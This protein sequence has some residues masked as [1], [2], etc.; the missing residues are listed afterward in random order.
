MV[1]MANTHNTAP[2]SLRPSRKPSDEKMSLAETIDYIPKE[3]RTPG[4]GGDLN[5]RFIATLLIVG[6]YL[7][8][9]LTACDEISFGLVVNSMVSVA[10]ALLIAFLAR[11]WCLLT[12]H[13]RSR[14][15]DAPAGWVQWILIYPVYQMIGLLLM[16]VSVVWADYRPNASRAAYG[17]PAALQW[18]LIAFSLFL[19]VVQA[20]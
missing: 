19:F 1:R 6:V 15:F 18:A 5:W 4:W 13:R 12:Y 7:R 16:L 11:R 10:V 9:T 14:G 2:T 8:T 20:F 3:S 17:W